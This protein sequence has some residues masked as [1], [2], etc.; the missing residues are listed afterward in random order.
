MADNEPFAR[1]L[2]PLFAMAAAPNGSWLATGG[3]DRTL[4]R[5]DPIKHRAIGGPI[6]ADTRWVLAVAVTP[7]G[8]QIVTGGGDGVVRI[9]DVAT[10]RLIRSFSTSTRMIWTISISADG[11]Q[12][13]AG[14]DDGKLRQW[15]LTDGRLLN[16]FPYPGSVRAMCVS[17]ATDQVVWAGT[18]SS[19][20]RASPEGTFKD[21]LIGHTGWVHSLA[22]TPDG[23][24][25][26]SGG[27]DGTIR[28]WDLRSGLAVGEPIR[29]H[30]GA[31]FTVVV[32]SD[33]NYVVSGG[34]DG[35]VRR[36]DLTS[37]TAVGSPHRG[38]TDWVRAIQSS[39]D[40]TR[41]F[42]CSNDGTIA[43]WTF[44]RTAV[45]TEAFRGPAVAVNA[46]AVDSVR[47]ELISASI[48]GSIR[49]WH[50]RTGKSLGRFRAPDGWVNAIA[51]SPDGN[52]L[53]RVGE[54]GPIVRWDPKTGQYSGEPLT[55]H[56]GGV[57][58]VTF[59]PD[60]QWIITAGA[61][62]TVRRWN[63]DTGQPV[64]EPLT[65]HRGEV[66]AVCVTPDGAQIIA[67]GSKDGRLLRWD[68]KTGERIGEA[69]SAHQHAALTVSV[70]RAGNRIVS[71]GSDGR[72]RVWDAGTGQPTTS[73]N[74]RHDGSVTVVRF[75]PDG[76]SII[77][78]A[79]DQLIREWDS[80]TGDP[81]GE[82]FGSHEGT[83]TSLAFLDDDGTV[84][85]SGSADGTVRRWAL[86]SRTQLSADAASPPMG[87]EVLADVQSDL[88]SSED[89][90]D[91]GGDV[92]LIGA[93]LA[94]TTVRPPLSIAVLGDWGSG[95]STFMLQLREWLAEA[96][97]RSSE[98]PD[99]TFVSNIKQVTFNAWHYSDDHLWVGLVEH[100]FRELAASKITTDDATAEQVAQL[101]TTLSTR[102]TDRDRLTAD[103]EAI[104][105]IETDRGWFAA[106][107]APLRSVK[108]AKAAVISGGRELFSRRGWP[109][110]LL[111]LAGIAGIVVAT[112]F[113]QAQL[114]WIG[115][116]VGALAPVAA[117]WRTLRE[118]T[119]NLRKQ[120][121]R[122]KD[123]LDADIRKAD[124]ELARVE[125]AHRLH[126]LLA[127]ISTAERYESFRGLT[128]R[129]HHDLRRLS[130]D[131]ATARTA[132]SDDGGQGKPPLQRIVLYVD[133]LDRCTPQRVA[134]VL[135][136]VNLLL[137]MDLFMVVV[138]VDPRW[139]LKALGRHHRGLLRDAV[140]PLDYLDKIFHIPFALR[141]MGTKAADFLRSMLP[142]AHEPDQIASP[143][144]LTNEVA[145][146]RANTVTAAPSRAEVEHAVPTP[147]AAERLITS[148]SPD[149]V[150]L[151]PEGMRIQ[152]FEQDFLANLVWLLPTPRATKKLAN[153]YRL[154]R[155]S[156]P[157]EHLEYFLVREEY[158]A[159]ALLLAALV[160][161]PQGAR[162]LL[163]KLADASGQDITDALTD[164]G[165][166]RRLSKLIKAERV[167][168]RT[169]HGE[170]GTYRRWATAVAR[171]GFETYDLFVMTF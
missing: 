113:G 64:G 67:A 41:V 62:G 85:F 150:D 152:Q 108:V 87:R 95:K 93:M 57:R 78:G 39:S 6:N 156:V 49:R 164:D 66:N 74:Q 126:R 101:K 170:I 61:D 154:V 56:A 136:A 1:H 38:H 84:L 88:E 129:I 81:V 43:R 123:E 16:T 3:G 36:W 45:H 73:P 151:A 32:T 128:G 100:M 40:G 97:R 161:D 52:Q 135:Q 31:V 72:I 20:Q 112:S 124:D 26:V 127:E 35:T 17:L 30:E 19:I 92:R 99:S 42:S 146:T 110:L 89:R 140:T 96:A 147:M 15:D 80:E 133:D 142:V 50:S 4:R 168:G 114:T 83:I 24:Q 102:K 55:G 132:W 130:E 121:L 9:W 149:E 27:G 53:V 7:D 109:Y 70:D 69:I 34:D 163:V 111:T 138:A 29:A 104:D 47:N 33:G 18:D 76:R 131:L 10:R 171:Y 115:I 117:A 75:T 134:D 137:T 116:T 155:L 106:A 2:W 48:D 166:P 107:R 46:L 60:S 153:L 28:Q 5:W 141:P 118:S 122:R 169:V 23:T 90:L 148:R 144:E 162:E 94:A 77:S 79:T 145:P 91:I 59:T 165:L 12:V 167:Q 11:T 14:G 157:P 65:G 13:F 22:L 159:A 86:G 143:D 98:S 119:E 25:L 103:L 51:L 71:G 120:L 37:G 58:A 54:D 160:S 8:Q 21:P 139:L 125:P 68:T 82:P 44:S 158:Q 105:R 63:R